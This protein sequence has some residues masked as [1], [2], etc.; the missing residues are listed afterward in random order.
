MAPMRLSFWRMRM[1]ANVPIP[2]ISCRWNLVLFS[3]YAHEC[4][5]FPF[6]DPS[7]KFVMTSKA[8]HSWLVTWKYNPKFEMLR[9]SLTCSIRYARIRIGNDLSYRC[10][11]A[12]ADVY[13]LISYTIRHFIASFHVNATQLQERHNPLLCSIWHVLKRCRV[14]LLILRQK[15]LMRLVISTTGAAEGR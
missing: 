6:F 11:S 12:F 7:P 13:N 4:S 15:K 14:C 10:K 9:V 8:V 3:C 1:T 2:Y 5:F